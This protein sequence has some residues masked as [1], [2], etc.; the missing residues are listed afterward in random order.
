MTFRDVVRAMLRRWYV[1]VG[2][3]AIGAALTTALLGLPR[4]YT[5]KTVVIFTLSGAS[6]FMPDNGTLNESVIDFAS[7]VAKEVNDPSS[8]QYASVDAPFY[9][10]GVRQGT[11]VRVPN[12]GGQWTPTSFSSA[13]I[14]I[15]IVSPDAAWVRAQQNAVLKQIKSRTQQQQ[16]LT[17]SSS[18][19]ITA[20]VE[21]LTTEI[22][23]V[24]PSKTTKLMAIAAP[25]LASVIV[26]VWLSA[27]VDHIA[28]Q[29]H[30][31][32]R[33]A[34]VSS[35]SMMSRGVAS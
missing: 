26:S 7:T 25:G 6:S 32:S 27:T 21:P 33:A 3:L 20:T 29:R 30:S 19:R 4:L 9:G 35:Q 15:Q 17:A 34:R 22:S 16:E 28:G 13:T 11:M 5:T 18:G 2:V 10:A 31:H 8:P 23:Q 12:N 1:S 24:A 14:E